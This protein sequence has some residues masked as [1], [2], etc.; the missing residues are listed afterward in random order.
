M[1][2]ALSNSID[3]IDPLWKEGGCNS[4]RICGL[5]CD[6]NLISAPF[7]YNASKNNAFVP[8]RL[9][10]ADQPHRTAGDKGLFLINGEWRLTEFL[11]R[12]WREEATKIGY[13][14]TKTRGLTIFNNG[15]IEVFSK[16]APEGFK[17]GRLESSKKAISRA[18]QGKEGHS[19]PGLKGSDHPLFQAK[20]WN[21]GSEE[22]LSLECPEGW[23]QGRV[24][25]STFFSTNGRKWWNNGKKEI[26][27][28]ERPSAEW[29]RGRLKSNLISGTSGKHFWT[30]GLNNK[31]SVECPGEGWRRGKLE[32]RKTITGTEPIPGDPTWIKKPNS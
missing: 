12:E 2:H 15:L 11:S 25:L 9:I 17:H 26:L 8:Y 6:R 1:P 21:N 13:A 32:N 24:N 3:H 31:V 30:D 19:H 10:G 23:V 7:S 22:T 28:N 20:W 16:N 29:M 18:H 27:A 5:S 14:H 4:N